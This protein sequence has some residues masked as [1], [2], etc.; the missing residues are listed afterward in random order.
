MACHLEGFGS[1][2]RITRMQEF[3]LRSRPAQLAS[4]FRCLVIPN[5]SRS[6]FLQGLTG[7]GPHES[8]SNSALYS[9]RSDPRLKSALACIQQ[10]CWMH[11]ALLSATAI[12]HALP[13][14]DGVAAALRQTTGSSV[15]CAVLGTRGESGT[16]LM[17]PPKPPP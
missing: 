11:S 9:T 14:R 6:I 15:L 7:A 2:R 10:S 1:R 13:W 17:E 16:A 12:V 4:K 8:M 3:T 5:D